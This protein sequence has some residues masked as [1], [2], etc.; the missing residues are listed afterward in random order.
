MNSNGAI[1]YPSRY[2]AMGNYSEFVR[3]G[4][5]MI[6]NSDASTFTTYDAGS[7]TLVIVTTNATSTGTTAT[8]DLSRFSSV[9]SAATPYRTSASENL[10]QLSPISIAHSQ[11]SSAI[12]ADSITTFVVPNV[13]YSGTD[14]MT[15]VDDS[16]QGSGLNQF[17]YTGSAWKHCTAG[18]WNDS[19]GLYDDSTSWDGTTNDAVSMQ[20]N[21]TRLHLFAVK[22]TNEGIGLV[23]VDHGLAHEVDFYAAKRAGNQLLWESTLLPPGAHT[24]QLT[25]S[26]RKNPLS[27]ADLIAPDRV[28]IDPGSGSGS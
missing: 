22:D 5:V 23:S 24:F 13:T 2:Y 27:S 25:V 14:A 3:P 7:H 12:P 20:F 17:N 18:C 26:G 21:G 11:F 8:Y 9:G 19:S 6:G 10:A 15:E 4:T 1:S 28:E 16:V